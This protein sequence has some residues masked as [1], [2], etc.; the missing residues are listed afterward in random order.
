MLKCS[1]LEIFEHC[2]CGNKPA[3]IRGEHAGHRR[4]HL[5]QSSNTLDNWPSW[6]SSKSESISAESQT[7]SQPSI[8]RYSERFIIGLRRKNL[9]ALKEDRWIAEQVHCRCLH[10]VQK[11]DLGPLLARYISFPI[12]R[13]NPRSGHSPITIPF[14]RHSDSLLAENI[15]A[16]C[17]EPDQAASNESERW[18]LLSRVM[19]SL[20]MKI[21]QMQ[22]ASA[23]EC[24]PAAIWQILYPPGSRTQKPVEQCCQRRM[25]KLRWILFT[26]ID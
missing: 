16:N 23:D 7:K 8:H 22:N 24:L 20:E 19:K 9:I 4:V 21:E 12:W 18:P 25:V 2:S 6:I 26:P 17:A 15:G 1:S 3:R 11:H 14:E 13:G 5:M 10:T